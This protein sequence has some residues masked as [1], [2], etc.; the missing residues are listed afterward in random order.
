MFAM[1]P[2]TCLVNYSEKGK[3]NALSLSVNK[4]IAVLNMRAWNRVGSA[5]NVGLLRKF[6]SR[7]FKLWTKVAT[8]YTN[9]TAAI[10]A[11]TATQIVDTTNSDGFILQ[12][13]RKMGLIGLTVSNSATGG[14]YTFEYYNGTT[15]ATLTTIENF[16]N[17]STTGDKYLAFIPPHDWAVGDGSATAID[18]NMYAIRVLHT[19]APGDTGSVNA[20]WMGE[21]LDYWEGVA[22]NVAVELLFDCERPFVLDGGEGL[23]PYFSTA[24][25][26]NQFGAFYSQWE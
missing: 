7:D 11:G 21:F 24:A 18:Q 20:L 2:Q 3:S 25:A 13:T 12:C 10:V 8:V 15:W 4:Q 9:V 1:P 5:I 23:F 14:T 16:T 22:D 19:T 26:A 6:N 17:F